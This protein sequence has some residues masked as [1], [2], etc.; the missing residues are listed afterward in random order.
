MA[1][2][3]AI[4][5][6]PRDNGPS[7]RITDAFLD[8]AMGLSTNIITLHRMIKFK[9]LGDCRRCME[10]KSTGIC[11]LHDDLTTVLDDIRVSVCVVFATPL[12]FSGPCAMYKVLEDRMY[13]FLN[14]DGTS[15]LPAG[16]K[17]VLIVTNCDPETD[18]EAVSAQMAKNLEKIGFEMMD[19]ITYCD[20]KAAKADEPIDKMLSHAKQVGLKMRN[21]PTV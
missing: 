5:C 2:I 6:S 20:Y 11:T 9:M 8:G 13:S 19:I 7:S 16:K 12:Y 1:K 4:T 14:K 15:N 18:N 3:V 21:T 17:A 10:C